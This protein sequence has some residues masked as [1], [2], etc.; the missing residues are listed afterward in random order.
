M[1][2]K[3]EKGLWFVEFVCL[4]ISILLITLFLNICSGSFPC[5]S[6]EQ[7]HHVSVAVFRG[8]QDEE[9]V[10]G[11]AHHEATTDGNGG[12]TILGVQN[13][14][15]ILVKCLVAG[16]TAWEHCGW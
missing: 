1:V 11:A 3:R 9:V 7:T 5:V 10:A 8:Q 15:A 2:K 16:D 13:T 6:A 4:A 14:I 12:I